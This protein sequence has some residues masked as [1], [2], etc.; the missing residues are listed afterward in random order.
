VK[1]SYLDDILT[2]REIAFKYAE[3]KSNNGKVQWY[4]EEPKDLDE[5]FRVWA[6]GPVIMVQ[7]VM[8][9]HSYGEFTLRITDATPDQSVRIA[10]HAA[11]EYEKIRAS[12]DA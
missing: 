3:L 7:A 10:H 11:K 1:R 6:E 8:W 9:Y 12:E 2:G 5:V 4:D